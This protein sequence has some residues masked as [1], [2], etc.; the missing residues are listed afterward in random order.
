MFFRVRDRRHRL[1][2]PPLPV[3]ALETVTEL[4]LVLAKEQVTTAMTLGV[5]L[6]NRLP[7]E[8]FQLGVLPAAP[9]ETRF[10]PCVPAASPVLL[11]SAC[12]SD[13]PQLAC[14]RPLS[15]VPVFPPQA[16][17]TRPGF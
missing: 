5:G 11:P 13:A 17:S 15:Y 14:A 16:S 12:A 2:A 8:N 9:A 3:Q 4:R 10:R 1:P 6:S 7:P